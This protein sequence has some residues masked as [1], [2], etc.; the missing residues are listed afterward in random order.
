[1]TTANPFLGRRR[2]PVEVETRATAISWGFHTND[3]PPPNFL[4]DDCGLEPAEAAMSVSAFHACVRAI[5]EGV[6]S[7]PWLLYRE[8]R[9]GNVVAKTHPYYRL[10]H[11]SPNSYQT[12]Y[13][14]RETLAMNAAIHGNAYALKRY[15]SRGFVSEMIPI[16]P[17]L[18]DV[19]TIE[20]NE[21]VY[22]YFDPR[23]GSGRFTSD[24]IIH[25][26][27]L[28]DNGFLGMSPI[29]LI[30]GTVNLAR[31]MDTYAQRFW[32]NDA[33]PGLI[34]ESSQP[35]PEEAMAAL[36]RQWNS[37]HRG[38]INA[39]KTAVL[40]VGLSLKELSGN[41][42]EQ[43]Q[44]LELRTF[45]VQEIARAMR[46][47]ASIIGENSQA[48]YGNVEQE[49]L[50]FV[51]NTLTP[52]CCR[53]E[54]A[55]Q[56]GLL[57]GMD[58]YSNQLDVRGLLRGDTAARSAYY[59]AGLTN[60]WFTINEVRRLEDLPPF[61]IEAA[62]EPLVAANNMQPLSAFETDPEPPAPALPAP[63]EPAPEE[64]VDPQPQEDD[65]AIV[66]D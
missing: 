41:T 40:P 37:L 20:G 3:L 52:W 36:K 7:I 31:A 47:P 61:D 8:T 19:K 45:I 62:N 29:R 25:I 13:E 27:Y 49:A 54:S 39:G 5:A 43:A 66:D 50:A 23:G 22:D 63:A 34:L 26:R 10:L 35:I 11:D 56:R 6:A 16:H 57:G 44:M 59:V 46:V 30:R 48:K 58:R 4:F 32:E 60:G 33:K 42:A 53:F 65:D 1:M 15:D 51:Q 12:S 64:P 9:D 14:F 21:I 38:P 17:V 28:A 55:I 2:S 18:I 24:E